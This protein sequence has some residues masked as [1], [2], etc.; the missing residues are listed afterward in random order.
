MEGERAQAV[1]VMRRL[2]L[3][4]AVTTAPLWAL[5]PAVAPAVAPAVGPAVAPAVGPAPRVAPAR[6][7]TH[8]SHTRIVLEGAVVLARVRMFRDDLEKALKRKITDD[9]AAQGA[10]AQYVTKHFLVRADGAALAGEL[11]DGGADTDG[12][13]KIWWVLVQ[14]KAAAPVK[15]LGV[16]AHVLFETFDDQQNLVVVNKQPGDER[17]SLYFQAGDR[18]EQTLRF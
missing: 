2:A 1:A 17:R 15:A 11:L 12:D 13:Q 18:S 9:A 4:I 10:V 3:L 16:R 7:N 14:W 8:I 5:P 6:H